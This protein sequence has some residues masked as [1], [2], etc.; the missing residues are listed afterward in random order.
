MFLSYFVFQSVLIFS[1]CRWEMQENGREWRD[2]EEGRR[3]GFIDGITWVAHSGRLPRDSIWRAS[4][5][6]SVGYRKNS[7][8]LSTNVPLILCTGSSEGSRIFQQSSWCPSY[9]AWFLL[10]MPTPLRV[11]SYVEKDWPAQANRM[12]QTWLS[13]TYDKRPCC[14]CLILF[15]ITHF[16]RSQLPCC[17][18]TQGVP[19]RNWCKGKTTCQ[20][21]GL[22]HQASML[23]CSVT[24][25]SLRP[26]GQ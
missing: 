7:T 17:K 24:S 6:I 4:A 15:W 3:W 25:N 22:T 14:F 19:R 20:Q 10:L 13:V 26:H 12:L 1:S 2:G 11:A 18:D 23:G 16:R 8:L 5:Q 9:P 21:Q